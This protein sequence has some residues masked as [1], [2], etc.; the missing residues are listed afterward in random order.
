MTDIRFFR[1]GGCV[2]D[3]L[4]GI[5]S[6]DIDF[7]VEAP[8]FDAML[9]AVEARCSKVFR[10]KDGSPI[11]AEFFTLRGL[12]PEL[13]PVDFVLCRK[14]G[15]SS[16]GRRPDFVE[17]GTLF[18]DLARRDFRCNAMAR[19]EFGTLIDP[20]GGRGDTEAH[21]LNFVGVA[22]DRLA[23]DALRAFRALRF[24]VTKGFDMTADC[25]F[26]IGS[27][28]K[29]AFDG[30]S[31]ERI[32]DELLKMFAK[33]TAAALRVL[34]RFPLLLEVALDRGLW[35]KPTTEKA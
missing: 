11:G 7:A 33:D 4:L 22:E 18:D 30:V 17:P 3:E 15:P 25:E 28:H 23:E 32:R 29:G 21:R 12:D 19:D 31:T 24:A 16:D 1:V 34:M 27:M 14:D 26:A 10:D 9:A 6:K 5:E 20:F 2:R 13:G 8:S 35:L